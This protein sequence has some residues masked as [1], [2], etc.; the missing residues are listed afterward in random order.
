MVK[1]F[2]AEVFWDRAL[3]L[4]DE[5]QL[6]AAEQRIQSR[7]EGG[8]SLEEEINRETTKL[9]YMVGCQPKMK[10]FLYLKEAIAY[11]VENQDRIGVRSKTLYETIGRKFH[12]SGL[13]VQRNITIAIKTADTN[14]A[15]GLLYGSDSETMEEKTVMSTMEFVSL[16]AYAVCERVS[17]SKEVDDREE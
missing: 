17:R 15:I 10:G 8:L 2:L 4:F 1:P 7:M 13:N 3:M 14:L 16:A 12:E 9:L 6:K 11:M 5:Q